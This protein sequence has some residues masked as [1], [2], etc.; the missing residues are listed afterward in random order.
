MTDLEAGRV[1]C[2]GRNSRHVDL[3]RGHVIVVF[4]DGQLLRVPEGHRTGHVAAECI[5]SC[6][7]D[8]MKERCNKNMKICAKCRYDKKIKRC[9][10]KKGMIKR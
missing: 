9:N 8:M 4:E 1:V 10:K 3:G 6:S 2:A 5:D 7:K